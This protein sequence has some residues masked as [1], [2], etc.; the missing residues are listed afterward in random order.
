MAEI[1]TKMKLSIAYYPQT[2]EQTERTNQILETYLQHYVNH[3]QKNWIQL[4][5]MTQL[6]LN[7]KTLIAIGE[8]VFY[9]NFGRHPNLFNIPRKSLQITAVLLETDQLRNI[10]KEI[11]RNIEYHQK[12][13]ES[14]INKKRMKKS[15]LK[16]ENKIYL[17]IKNL[18]IL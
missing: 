12:Y 13:S 3:S 17:F 18:K 11:S 9:A 14:Q 16:E 6:A 1:G 2:D 4:L 7:N 15:Q 10:Y 8:L 5:S